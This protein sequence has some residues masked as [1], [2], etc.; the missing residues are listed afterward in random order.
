[1]RRVVLVDYHKFRNTQLAYTVIVPVIENFYHAKSVA[2]ASANCHRSEFDAI[3]A[4]VSASLSSLSPTS[5]MSFYSRIGL[6]APIVATLP[7]VR[8]KTPTNPPIPESRTELLGLRVKGALIG[9]LIYDHWLKQA[10][11]P[12]V[13]LSSEDFQRFFV[14]SIRI[15][16]Y[17]EEFFRRNQ[18]VAVV[19]EGVYRN[20]LPL[21]I[22]A[23][24]GIPAYIANARGI[25]RILDND[26]YDDRLSNWYPDV[27][28]KLPESLRNS[29]LL[30]SGL[31]LNRL[32]SGEHVER[33]TGYEGVSPFKTNGAF[34]KTSAAKR[35]ELF[36][37]S[38][39]DPFDSPHVSGTH[40]FED[41]HQWLMGL[42][43][44]SKNVPGHW[45]LKTHPTLS[46]R[47]KEV[48]KEFSDCFPHIEILDSMTPIQELVREGL[49]A[50]FTVRGTIGSEYPLLG[51]HVINASSS[52]PHVRYDFNFHP[53]TI[54]EWKDL[55]RSVRNL[56]K[57]P[58]NTEGIEEYFFMRN[59]FDKVEFFD[60]RR[61]DNNVPLRLRFVS[62]ARRLKWVRKTYPK[63]AINVEHFLN[64]GGRWLRKTH[65][66]IQTEAGRDVAILRNL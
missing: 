49:V 58:V 7:R 56:A 36:L 60:S 22:A 28:R 31:S 14:E 17:F 19:G 40:L 50:A 37:I 66:I 33:A 15:F 5:A 61:E 62:R 52:N 4:N 43:E 53:K 9:D 59:I 54:S 25:D 63:L 42:G 27:F 55:V 39:H 1:M 44:L 34:T 46:E 41:Y 18:V 47:A 13:D 29:A 48:I 65:R 26:P 35:G 2:Y 3:R 51:V 20:A 16:E 45:L 57:L 11:V 32:I 23:A 24:R 30:D 8:S 21:R 10:S 12:T 6:S 64:E 38:P